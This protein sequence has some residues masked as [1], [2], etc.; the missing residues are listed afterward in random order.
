MNFPLQGELSLPCGPAEAIRVAVSVLEQWWSP[1]QMELGGGTALAARWMHRHS[2]DVDLFIQSSVYRNV[3]TTQSE[4]LA[5]QFLKFQESG[6]IQGFELNRGFLDFTTSHGAVS[7][8]TIA[9]VL[10]MDAGIGIDREICTKVPLEPTSEILAKKLSGRIWGKGVFYERDAYDIA[11]AG[12]YE[13]A[14]LEKAK[15]VLSSRE[16]K[17]ISDE[18][19]SLA[20]LGSGDSQSILDPVFPT[21]ASRCMH[22][23]HEALEEKYLD[24]SVMKRVLS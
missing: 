7:L 3:E 22:Y 21:V 16:L 12:I 14:A 18:F 19:H 11:I 23:A 9:R 8:M 15:S 13:P 5:E 24:S 2:T 20:R 4:I 17:S 1:N 10:E 6:I